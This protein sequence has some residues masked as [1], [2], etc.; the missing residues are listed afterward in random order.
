MAFASEGASTPFITSTPSNAVTLPLLI[1]DV[2]F[3]AGLG[4]GSAAVDALVPVPLFA[5]AA[6]PDPAMTGAVAT[7]GSIDVHSHFLNFDISRGSPSSLDFE[8]LVP[9][10]PSARTTGPAQTAT[11]F[12]LWC[13]NWIWLRVTTRVARSGALTAPLNG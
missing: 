7:I 5:G 12:R 6:S 10:T 13:G 3:R 2:G 4:A 11:G 8:S 1:A 9:V